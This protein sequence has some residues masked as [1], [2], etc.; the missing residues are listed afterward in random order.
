MTQ[1]RTTRSKN[2]SIDPAVLAEL[3]TARREFVEGEGDQLWAILGGNLSEGAFLQM[4][5]MAGI[6]L[7]RTSPEARASLW[8]HLPATTRGYRPG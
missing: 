7:M 5:A 2:Y 4:V 8:N 3:S 1:K 6:E